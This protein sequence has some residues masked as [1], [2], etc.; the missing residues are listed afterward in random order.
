MGDKWELIHPRR[1]MA[2]SKAIEH[3]E[4][5]LTENHLTQEDRDNGFSWTVHDYLDRTGA[6]L[7]K[8]PWI[9]V[10]VAEVSVANSCGGASYMQSDGPWGIAF[11]GQVERCLIALIE[12][13]NRGASEDGPNYGETDEEFWRLNHLL[14]LASKVPNAD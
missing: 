8:R 1:R 11:C 6:G 2:Y 3:V 14:V 5:W 9:G 12:G 7:E 13:W 4:R 10:R